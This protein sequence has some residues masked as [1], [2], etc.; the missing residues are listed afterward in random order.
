MESRL[1][2]HEAWFYT[3]HNLGHRSNRLITE[4]RGSVSLVLLMFTVAGLYYVARISAPLMERV[5]WADP[6]H[7]YISARSVNRPSDLEASSASVLVQEAEAAKQG[8]VDAAIRLWAPD[9]TIADANLKPQADGGDRTWIGISQVK[10]RY[11]QEFQERRYQSLRHLNLR[12]EVRGKE[13]VIINDLSAVFQSDG[14]THHVSLPK[15][16]RWVLRSTPEGWKIVRLEV[17]RI[18]RFSPTSIRE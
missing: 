3:F 7:R 1:P 16:D 14:A 9:G 13:A 2:R 11:V 18:P 10:Q 5:Q 4:A 17:N 6:L 8:D 12:V 15:S